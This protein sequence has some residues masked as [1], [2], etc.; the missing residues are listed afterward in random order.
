MKARLWLVLFGILCLTA[1]LSAQRGGGHSGRSSSGRSSSSR[2]YSG[3]SSSGRSYSGRSYSARGGSRSY[4]SRSGGARSYGSGSYI[5]RGHG[6][7]SKSVT[8]SSPSISTGSRS[9]YCTTCIRSANGRIA[10]SSAAKD[11]FKHQHPCPSTGSSTGAC[12]GFVIDHVIP[13]KRGGADSPSNMQW[14]TVA[15]AKAKDKIE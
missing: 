12:S 2:V 13:L 15:D 9:N 8:T 3:R 4:T 5:P 14:Q 7:S 1:P 6:R 10:R 11:E